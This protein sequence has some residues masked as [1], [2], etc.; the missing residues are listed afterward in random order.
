MEIQEV[1]R[2]QFSYNCALKSASI[3]MEGLIAAAHDAIDAIL[4]QDTSK[5]IDSTDQRVASLLSL[6]RRQPILRYELLLPA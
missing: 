5:D 6:I 2:D 1:V 4:G 3:E